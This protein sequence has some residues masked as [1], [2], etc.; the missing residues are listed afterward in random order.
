MWTIQV[1]MNLSWFYIFFYKKIKYQEFKLFITRYI[2]NIETMAGA[3]SEK[4][5][6]SIN[7]N[8]QLPKSKEKQIG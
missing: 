2:Q 1:G 4:E 3:F 7:Q 5:M 6:D 8:M